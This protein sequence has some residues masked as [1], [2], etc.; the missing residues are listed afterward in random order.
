M[1]A[2]GCAPCME[3][4]DRLGWTGGISFACHGLRIGI[5][6]NNLSVLERIP[7]YLAPG[8]NWSSS[9]NVDSLFSLYVGSEKSGPN[10]RNYN[11]LYAGSTRITR[12]LELDQVLETLQR[13]LHFNVVIGA[14]NKI[15][16]HAGV[17]GWRGRAIVIPGRSITGKAL[18]AELV[19]TGATYYSDEFAVFDAYGRVHPYSRVVLIRQEAKEPLQRCVAEAL[20]DRADTRPI[21][22]GLVAVITSQPSVNWRPRFL[23]P[24]QT[25]LALMGNVILRPQAAIKF[26]QPV[27]IGAA[28]LEQRRGDT[29]KLA[30][31]LLKQT[32]KAQSNQRK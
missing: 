23:T 11:L 13:F 21:P 24:G 27:V 3:K 32:E 17:V 29:P 1:R 22:V 7:A 30:Q 31:R 10:V 19:R 5:R 9:P 14:Q 25:F 4:L 15:F 16:V 8:W 6:V 2:C 18:V 26:L 12:A 28:A 20:G